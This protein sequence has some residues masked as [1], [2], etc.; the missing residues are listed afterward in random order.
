MVRLAIGRQVTWDKVNALM[1]KVVAAGRKPQLLAGHDHK[2]KGFRLEDDKARGV[3]RVI[4]IIAYIDGKA[5][6]QPPG[7]IEAKC[8]Q[9]G[10]RRQID[11]AFLRELVREQVKKFDIQVVEIEL[12]GGLAFADVVRTIDAARTCCYETAVSVRLKPGG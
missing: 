11:R 9:S 4:S 1:D 6:V 8:V 5:C 7:A 3:D 10:D 12:A 2:V